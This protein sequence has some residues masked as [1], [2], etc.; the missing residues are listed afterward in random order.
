MQAAERQQNDINE[1]LER[2]EQHQK[3]LS[4]TLE[5]YERNSQEILGG[6]SGN[7]RTLDTGPAD[8]ERDKK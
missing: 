1:A 2:I 7:L 3:D 4:A 5:T 6:Q 8:T